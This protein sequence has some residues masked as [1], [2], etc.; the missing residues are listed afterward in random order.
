MKPSPPL[1]T[2]L[3]IGG[4]TVFTVLHA[5]AGFAATLGDIGDAV[6]QRS[7]F[8]PLDVV[9]TF[10]DRAAALADEWPL[11]AEAALPDGVVWVAFPASPTSGRLD[12]T[13]VRAAAPAGWSNDKAC[14]VDAQWSALRFRYQPPRLK[15]KDAARSRRG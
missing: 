6:W 3:E 7:L 11:L 15:P 10:H 12:A 9:V 4:D 2:K 5:P 14:S 13:A 1:R 8:A